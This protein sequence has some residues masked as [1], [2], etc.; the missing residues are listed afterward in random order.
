MSLALHSREF[1]RAQ[2]G[3]DNGI[4]VLLRQAGI[5]VYQISGI[6]VRDSGVMVGAL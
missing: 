5:R 3:P 6:R 4:Y 2:Q 1:H